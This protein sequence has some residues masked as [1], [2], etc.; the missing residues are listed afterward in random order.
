MCEYMVI[1]M[2]TDIHVCSHMHVLKCV[3]TCMFI[4]VCKCV[5]VYLHAGA[6][7]SRFVYTCM[8]L[9]ACANICIYFTDVAFYKCVFADIHDCAS[10]YLCAK[11]CVC[12][13]V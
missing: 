4:H 13:Y 8:Y 1:S 9:Q 10:E 11:V 5:C 3:R 6:G 2:C 12:E 7:A